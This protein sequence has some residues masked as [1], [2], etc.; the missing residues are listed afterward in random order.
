MGH[1]LETSGVRSAM[2][3]D[4]VVS[5]QSSHHLVEQEALKVARAAAAS[6]RNRP[7]G[8]YLSQLRRGDPM[9]GPTTSKEDN[10]DE[11]PAFR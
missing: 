7:R 1:L 5:E 2:K 9:R 10:S 11:E 3:H 6:L 4:E 8:N